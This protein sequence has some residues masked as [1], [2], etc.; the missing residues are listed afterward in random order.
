MLT[1]ILNALKQWLWLV[2]AGFVV[3]QLFFVGRVAFMAVVDPSSTAFERSQAWQIVSTQGRIN[4][5]QQW[6]SDDQIAKTLKR[7]VLASEDSAFTTHKGIW[8]D[9]IEKACKKMPKPKPN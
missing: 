7:A 9:A 2:L 3:L 4:W 1:S 5:R 6:Q 8:W